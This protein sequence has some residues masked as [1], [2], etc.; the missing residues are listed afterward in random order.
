MAVATG[1][2]PQIRDRL[3]MLPSRVYFSLTIVTDPDR[4][5]DYNRWHQLD[6]VPENLLLPGV[7]WGERWVRSPD[8]DA[9]SHGSNQAYRDSHY[10]I[11]YWFREPLRET[12]DDWFHLTHRSFQWGRS[13]QVG[14]TR[15][16]MRSFF[17]PIKGYVAPR[18]LVSA[19]A[20][21]LRPTKAVHITLSHFNL[22]HPD[23]AEALR[24]YDQ[25]RLPELIQRRGVTGAW[26]LAE[27]PQFQAP[28]TDGGAEWPFADHSLRDGAVSPNRMQILYLDEEPEEV[29]A[30]IAAQD[31]ANMR[32]S[33]RIDTSAFED[34]MLAGPMRPVVPWEWN[35]FDSTQR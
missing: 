6:H 26:V 18:A 19:A 22:Q 5:D 11:M 21:P 8:C 15:R 28:W 14:W 29:L 1:E 4:H 30:D 23:A 31:R 12:L 9:L 13:S 34:V 27:D 3:T 20:L 2:T 25:V 33:P 7:A 10:G 16:P 35:W 17:S 32:T 24:W